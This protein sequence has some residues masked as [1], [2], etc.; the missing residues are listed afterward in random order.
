MGDL[1]E[2]FSERALQDRQAATSWYW[3]QTTKTATHYLG[4]YCASEDLLSKLCILVAIGLFST[5]VLMVS[6]LSNMDEAP[7]TIWQNLLQGKIHTFLL[8]TEV[9]SNGS[10]QLIACFDFEMYV[11]PPSML[12]ALLS[13]GVMWLRNRLGKFSAHQ[14][15]AWGC[16]L[17][18]LPYLFGLI[19][20][21]LMNPL[22]HKIGPT[23]AFM[24][25]S[26][27]YTILPLAAFVVYKARQHQ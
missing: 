7:E 17:M 26:V 25:I 20:I 9:L 11:N 12:W 16:T 15:A 22:P 13:F 19:Y 24:S 14:A 2:E 23:V 10:D 4:H 21:D 6:W 27:I 8:D 18:L 5:L 3:K 1:N